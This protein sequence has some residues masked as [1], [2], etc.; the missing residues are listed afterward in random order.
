MDAS[1]AILGNFTL[2]TQ[3]SIIEQSWTP[4][5][6]LC[7]V[8]VDGIF[9]MPQ[10]PGESLKVHQGKCVPLLLGI[11]PSILSGSQILTCKT[12]RMSRTCAE[13]LPPA[14]L[15]LWPILYVTFAPSSLPFFQL[16]WSIHFH[17]A[18]YH[19]LFIVAMPLCALM[20]VPVFN[21]PYPYFELCY[22]FIHPPP[23]Y[24][25]SSCSH[26]VVKPVKVMQR[27]CYLLGLSGMT[28]CIF[29][30]IPAKTSW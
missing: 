19:F 14:F 10:R 24:I 20:L 8:R 17:K 15:V 12:S 25:H 21:C 16:L 18:C 22:I 4:L 26:W 27:L 2:I 5:L 23:L 6:F 1:G 29:V 11:F 28:Y 3:W 30:F 13:V 9:S 7:P